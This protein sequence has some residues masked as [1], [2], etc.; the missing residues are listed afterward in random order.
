MFICSPVW[1]DMG[2][3]NATSSFVSSPFCTSIASGIYLEYVK[4]FWNILSK[5]IKLCFYS[6][7][8]LLISFCLRGPAKYGPLGP[9]SDPFITIFMNPNPFQQR[10]KPPHRQP[11]IC[12]L[13]R[14]ERM[15]CCQTFPRSMPATEPFEIYF[16]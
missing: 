8:I 1:Y 9:L 15:A 2:Q 13:H 6:I 14:G 11:T 10:R 3:E 4:L 5:S 7:I 12:K 16:Q